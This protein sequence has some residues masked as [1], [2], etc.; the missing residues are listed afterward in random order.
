[1][2][3]VDEIGHIFKRDVEITVSRYL[4]T[5]LIQ[6]LKATTRD[7]ALHELVHNLDKA[8]KLIHQDEFLHAIFEREKLVSTGIGLGVAIPHAKLEGYRDFFI[9]IGIQTAK[10]LEWHS[11]DG[12]PVRLI[13]M[14]G[15]PSD[16]QTDYLKILSRLTLAIKN[17]ELR[18]QMLKARTSQEV[19][20]LFEGW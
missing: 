18:L 13:F 8:G 12:A 6:F 11:L 5:P 4:S 2:E 17:E 20:E 9:A 1:M 19:L 16:R 15:G 10:G 7:E 14:I 3:R